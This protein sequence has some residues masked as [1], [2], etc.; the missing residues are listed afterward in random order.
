MNPPCKLGLSGLQIFLGE[1]KI[2][3]I[4]SLIINA[5]FAFLQLVYNLP[6]RAE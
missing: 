5:V 6:Y 4:H 1:P 2:A 3:V